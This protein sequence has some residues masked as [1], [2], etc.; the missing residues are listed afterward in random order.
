M[1]GRTITTFV[2]V[3][4]LAGSLLLQAKDTVPFKGLCFGKV[5]KSEGIF[6]EV[7][8]YGTHLGEFSGTLTYKGMG[9]AVVLVAANGD[10][11]RA[12]V[13]PFQ[14]GNGGTAVITGGTGRFTGATGKWESHWTSWDASTAEW[15]ETFSGE[16]SSVGSNEKE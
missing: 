16:V 3:A 13:T 9:L 6:A 5:V 1:K 4:L 14:N 15:I 11:L 7:W 12:D 2:S 8:G 10:E